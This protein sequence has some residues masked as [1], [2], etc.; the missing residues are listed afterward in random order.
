MSAS[1]LVLALLASSTQGQG[2]SSPSDDV[3]SLL[4][5]GRV[6]DATDRLIE[7]ADSGDGRCQYMLAQWTER[8]ELVQ[9]DAATAKKLYE[10][11]Y[12]AGI[13][14]AGAD[15]LR[16]ARDGKATSGGAAPT[17]KP[18][19]PPAAADAVAA[20]GALTASAPPAGAQSLYSFPPL[21]GVPQPGGEEVWSRYRPAKDTSGAPDMLGIRLG[22]RDGSAFPKFHASGCDAAEW[23]PFR[24]CIGYAALVTGRAEVTVSFMY[25]T[26]DQIVVGYQD[27]ASCKAFAG[28][29][30]KSFGKPAYRM[31]FLMKAFIAGLS[32]DVSRRDIGETAMWG[33]KD[34][35]MMVLFED[36]KAHSCELLLGS[37]D[38]D[39]AL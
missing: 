34:Q 28:F 24:K 29:A 17:L 12:Q 1:I 22:E 10:L 20:G 37:W 19:A 25:G 33:K 26:V 23:N 8:G 9:K 27:A 18:T 11:A 7:C 4:A 21:A 15:V 32:K 14:A 39:A 38:D 2:S 13:D 30:E 3:R 36:A 6:K 16:L 5:G 31:G 35:W